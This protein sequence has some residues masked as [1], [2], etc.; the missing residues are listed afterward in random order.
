MTI[1]LL[2][3][4][5]LLIVIASAIAL[6]L[7][8]SVV[9]WKINIGY[10]GDNRLYFGLYLY[11]LKIFT[12]QKNISDFETPDAEVNYESTMGRIKFFGNKFQEN[13][14]VIN[15]ILNLLNKN[16]E[17][18]NF[19]I[20]VDIGVGNA[21]LTGIVCGAAYALLGLV[22]GFITS[23]IAVQETCEL[24]VTPRHNK[25]VFDISGNV[26]IDFRVVNLFKM[27]RGI[28]KLGLIK[29]R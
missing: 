17:V 7:I 8:L 3:L 20:F 24:L 23:I 5:I 22:R 21:A 1:F 13:K 25:F 2:V 15:D 9:K 10:L 27:Y 11:R 26:V 16:V 6:A 12:F 14:N 19:S 29:T 18:Q 28:K 4:R